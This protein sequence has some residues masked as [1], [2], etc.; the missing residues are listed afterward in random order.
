MP[1]VIQGTDP[2]G[3]DVHHPDAGGT[4]GQDSFTVEDQASL[5]VGQ[6]AYLLLDP[7]CWDD[8]PNIWAVLPTGVITPSGDGSL[9]DPFCDAHVAVSDFVDMAISAETSR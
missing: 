1:G 9:A 4:V 6:T 8:T 3:A 2:E 7:P 5:V